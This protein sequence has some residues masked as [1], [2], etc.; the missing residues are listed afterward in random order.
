MISKYRKQ[1]NREFSQE[2]YN[3]FKEILKE[4][5]GFEP[6][7]RISESPLFLSKNFENKLLDA[8]E[9][10]IDQIK[11]LPVETLQKAIPNNLQGSQ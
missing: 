11:A 4:K 6:A 9:S 3:R 8:S 1:F 10:I 5:S 7:F 2:K